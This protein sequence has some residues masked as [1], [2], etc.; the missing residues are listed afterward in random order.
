MHYSDR[1]KLLADTLQD[2]D[3]PAWRADAFALGLSELRARKPR[4]FRPQLWALAACLALLAVAISLALHSNP[5]RRLT[6]SAPPPEQS[7]INSR[8]LPRNELVLSQPSQT[9]LVE[10]AAAPQTRAEKVETRPSNLP[11]LTDRE[12]LACFGPRA[13]GIIHPSN[14]TPPIV[15]FSRN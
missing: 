13:A 6:V 7:I 14:L 8:P 3:Y 5:G 12:L 1:D 9:L 4:S 15:V 10:T 2:A 11:E